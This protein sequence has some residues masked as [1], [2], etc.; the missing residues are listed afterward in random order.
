MTASLRPIGEDELHG[1]VDGRLDAERRAQ[2][3]RYLAANPAEAQRVAGWAAVTEA[4]RAA[5]DFKLREPIPP[6]LDIRRL[7]AAQ[8]E[9]RRWNTPRV[10]AGMVL[11]LLVGAGGGWL[12]HQPAPPNGV[13]VLAREALA[14]HQLLAPDGSGV[15]PADWPDTGLAGRVVAP[16]LS[17]AGYTLQGRQP[18]VTDE[19]V[20]LLVLY[21]NTAGE[22][23]SLFVRPMRKRDMTAPM[24][25]VGGAPGWAW[26][27]DGMGVSL[28]SSSPTP[29]LRN[30]AE[31]VRQSLKS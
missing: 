10:A 3:E 16:D 25:A 8:H 22:R 28:I 24:Q 17:A 18:V 6:G 7:A 2:V 11:A 23:I 13:T 27:T 26:A 29:A 19:G 20:A 14:A 9:A 21:A 31:H 4:L 12:A 15:Q 30:L 1:Y 5:L